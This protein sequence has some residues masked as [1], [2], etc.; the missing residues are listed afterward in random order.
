MN[1]KEKTVKVLVIAA[2]IPELSGLTNDQKYK[3]LDRL[4]T[5]GF[6]PGKGSDRYDAKFAK[7]LNL[8][9]E[10]FLG[11]NVADFQEWLVRK[12]S[13]TVRKSEPVYF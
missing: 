5:E 10:K 9:S 3:S 7:V 2:R 12:T 8:A 13:P 11:G 6:T 1:Q 4:I